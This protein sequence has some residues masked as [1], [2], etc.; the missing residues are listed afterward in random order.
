MLISLIGFWQKAWAIAAGQS[1]L[2]VVLAFLVC[3]W[4]TGF[5]VG[6]SG[7]KGEVWYITKTM[8]A[9]RPYDRGICHKE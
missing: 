7:K 8:N 9:L 3:T 5:W 1:I 6:C 4:V 2:L